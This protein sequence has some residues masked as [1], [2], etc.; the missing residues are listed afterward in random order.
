MEHVCYCQFNIF[1]KCRNITSHVWQTTHTGNICNRMVCS[2]HNAITVSTSVANNKYGQLM[3]TNINTDLLQA[4]I[5]NKR[6]NAVTDHFE[7]LMCKT[8]SYSNHVLFC[9]SSVQEP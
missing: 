3:K 7:S 8:C 2:A 9:N 4:A 1:F 5:R 6:G